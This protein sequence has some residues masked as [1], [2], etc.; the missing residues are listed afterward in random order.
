M[1]QAGSSKPRVVRRSG[2]ARTATRRAPGR[3]P[4]EVPGL[5]LAMY[6]AP[7]VGGRRGLTLLRVAGALAILGTALVVVADFLPYLVLD[8]VEVIAGQDVWSVL[9][10]LLLL[11]VVGGAGAVMLAGRGGRVG[12]ALIAAPAVT[13]PGLLLQHVFA[14]MEPVRHAGSEYYFGQLYT[15]AVIDGRIGRLLAVVGLALLLVAGIA[16]ATAWSDIAERD[17]LPLGASRRVAGGAAGLV[18]LLLLIAFLVPL[19]ATRI[20]KYTD[21]SGLVLTR[22]LEQPHSVVTTSGLDLAGGVLLLIGW[23]VAAA[24]VGAMTSR[25]TVVAALVGIG[26]LAL[27]EALMNL[28]EI[29]QGPDLVAGPRLYLLLTGAILALGTGWYSAR[30]RDGASGQL[31]SG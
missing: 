17:V 24:V 7:T 22:E 19:A 3:A 18:V 27:Y 9:G 29:T 23:V 31:P 10:H 12:P 20:V 15:T 21:P 4:A 13:A 16:A 5:G 6:V 1:T 28:R 2:G 8:D 26:A 11:V 14:G 25:V 30:V